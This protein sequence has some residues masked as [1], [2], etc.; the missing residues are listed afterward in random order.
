MVFQLAEGRAP[1]AKRPEHIL[2]A[3]WTCSMLAIAGAVALTG[4]AEVPTLSWLAIPIV[5]LSARFSTRGVSLGVGVAMVLLFAV[6]FGT[7]AGAVVDDPVLVLAPAALI[8]ATAILSTA[9]MQSDLHFRSENVIDPLT[10]MLNRKAL[11]TRVAELQQQSEVSGE[12][13]GLVVGDL[14]RFKEV[15]DSCG[16]VKGD[17]VLKDVAYEIRKEL[18]AF[19]LAY[20]LGGEEFLVIVPGS[21]VDQATALAERLRELLASGTFGGDQHVT[22]S[23]G[24]SAS[25]G[26]TRFEYDLVFAE[27]DAA[28]FEA[29]RLGRDRVCS[30]ARGAG[31]RPRVAPALAGTALPGVE[32]RPMTKAP[33]RPTPFASL[34]A[35][36]RERLL[37]ETAESWYHF[38]DS[39][40]VGDLIERVDGALRDGDQRLAGALIF[41]VLSSDDTNLSHSLR[42]GSA[43]NQPSM[44]S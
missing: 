27:A 30:A 38:G 36:S 20:R 14:D 1:R 24:V 8:A 40:D 12:P 11:T 7:D 44:R 23:F 16:H 42:A 17:A 29:K 5:T 13:I 10:G 15:N 31:P 21:D 39:A 25:T 28:L 18:R 33:E 37:A 3:A 26:A 9:L 34:E 19:D 6:A 4:G 35:S 41:A 43:D 32:K 2:F 22:M